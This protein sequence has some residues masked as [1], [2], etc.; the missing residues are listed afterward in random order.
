MGQLCIIDL[1]QGLC[2]FH[3]NGGLSEVLGVS[4]GEY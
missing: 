3:G 1:P 4:S 2:F